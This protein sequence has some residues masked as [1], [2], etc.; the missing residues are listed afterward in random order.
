MKLTLIFGEIIQLIWCI[1]PFSHTVVVHTCGSYTLELSLC[2]N[3][4]STSNNLS[5]Y[6][7]HLF[8]FENL[9]YWEIFHC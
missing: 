8:A 9:L 2:D 3:D 7:K 4:G 6:G 1:I 5:N